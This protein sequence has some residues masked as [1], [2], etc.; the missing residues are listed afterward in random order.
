MT[1]KIA[2]NTGDRLH[3]AK[4]SKILAEITPTSFKMVFW[5]NTFASEYFDEM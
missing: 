4:G 5:Q 1:I 3:M 2:W